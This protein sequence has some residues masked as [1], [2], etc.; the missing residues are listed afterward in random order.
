MSGDPYNLQRFVDAQAETISRVTRELRAGRK[1]SHW[2]WF[3][4]PQLTGLGRSP[5]SNRYGIDSR[6]EAEAYLAHPVLGPRLRECTQL[7]CS[8]EKQDPTAV[9]GSPDDLKF[10]SS[11]TLFETVG[12]ETDSFTAALSQYYDGERDEQTLALLEAE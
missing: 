8:L 2:M 4:F 11:M 7:V 3:I 9:F 5:T 10:R 1:Q 6:R 12:T